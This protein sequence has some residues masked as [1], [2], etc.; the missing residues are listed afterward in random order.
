MTRAGPRL[1]P[2]E[3]EFSVGRVSDDAGVLVAVGDI[4]LALGREGGVGAAIERVAGE[5][6]RRLTAAFRWS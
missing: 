5:A 2:R 1:A 4:D 3:H 6:G